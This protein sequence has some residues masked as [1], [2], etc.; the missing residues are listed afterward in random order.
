MILSG[1]IEPAG[2]CPLAPV[3]RGEG[4]GEGLFERA[5]TKELSAVKTD[6][7]ATPTFGTAC[8]KADKQ[9]HLFSWR[10]AKGKCHCFGVLA[11]AVPVTVHVRTDFR[12]QLSAV[13]TDFRATPT[14][15]T[16]CPRAD[17]QWHRFSWWQ[18]GQRRSE[19]P[20]GEPQRECSDEPDERQRFSR[21]PE[22]RWKER[23][24]LRLPMEQIV[25]PFNQDHT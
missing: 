7:R 21:G 13:K 25:F 12:Q 20:D 16:A 5:I 6:F 10:I 1:K 8:P 11:E 2:V 19:L 14:F 9:W 23:L 17:K 18:L 3:L 22:F 15:G 4:E 24:D